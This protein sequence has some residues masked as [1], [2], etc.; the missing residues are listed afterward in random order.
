MNE[1]LTFEDIVVLLLL[2][3]AVYSVMTLIQR[4]FTSFMEKQKKLY[5][6]GADVKLSDKQKS[7]LLSLWTSYKNKRPPDD[8]LDTML[9]DNELYEIKKAC[10]NNSLPDDLKKCY[11][12]RKRLKTMQKLISSG[13]TEEHAFILCGLIYNKI[14]AIHAIKSV[15]P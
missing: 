4:K 2:L 14:G 1:T 9:S 7:Y 6:W 13:Y 3:G 8:N 5:K 12:E 10:S 15:N 11:S